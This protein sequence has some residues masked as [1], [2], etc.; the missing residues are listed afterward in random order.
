MM[1]MMPFRRLF[2]SSYEKPLQLCPQDMVANWLYGV[3]RTT[4]LRANAIAAKRRKR[5][6]QVREMPE[7][8]MVQP[9]LWQDLQPLLDRALGQLP[10]N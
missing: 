6:R 10:D 7:P 8:E 3:A 1:P 9:E 2:S 4:A 5:E